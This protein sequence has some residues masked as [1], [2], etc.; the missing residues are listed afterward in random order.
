M[1]ETHEEG[2]QPHNQEP[3]SAGAGPPHTEVTGMAAELSASPRGVQ[4]ALQAAA[5][6]WRDAQHSRACQRVTGWR[7]CRQKMGGGQV[8]PSRIPGGAPRRETVFTGYRETE[9]IK[10][11]SR[12]VVGKR[13]LTRADTTRSW[14]R[15]NRVDTRWMWVWR[16]RAS[17]G[18]GLRAI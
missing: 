16:V 12:Y 3:G 4:G 9:T 6:R 1:E 15:M 14:P 10:E 17:Q 7:G 2:V 11:S 13:Q 18:A 8:A 5:G